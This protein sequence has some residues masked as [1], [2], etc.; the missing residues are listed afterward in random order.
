MSNG[1]SEIDNSKL[2]EIMKM[3][4]TPEMQMKFFEIF[5]VSQLFMP[6]TY[7][8][9]LFEGIENA[10]EGE[11]VEIDDHVGFNINYLTDKGGNNAVPL[12]TSTEIMEKIGLQS[13]AMAIFISDLAGML[14]QTDKYSV[15]AINPFTDFDLNL[16]VSAF[17][18]L[19]GK[20]DSGEKMKIEDITHDRL[21]ELLKN[22][23]NL[24]EDELDE[25]GDELFKSTLITGCVNDD[26]GTGFALIWDNE[27]VA[28][29]PLFTDIEEF[30]KI[31]SE[32]DEVF[33]QAYRFSD[34]LKIAK[35]DFVINPASESLKLNP[36]MF[37]Q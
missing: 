23:G 29:M 4:L 20:N 28:H 12:F 17:M 15:I 7:S 2:E 10:K 3:E 30:E 8:D 9:S 25:F 6:V 35:E 1:E 11:V 19:M 24:S 21:R 13:S 33:P 16:P 31:F 18:N 34:Y 5:K 22:R 26:E 27:N 36:E 14:S 32:Y 37:R